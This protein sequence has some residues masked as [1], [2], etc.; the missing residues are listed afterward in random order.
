M[1]MSAVA[2]NVEGT[3]ASIT[4]LYAPGEPGYSSTAQMIVECALF[5]VQEPGKL[6][7]LAAKGGVLTGAL[8]GANRLAERLV[9]NA[10]WTIQ[11]AQSY[12]GKS[13][14]SKLRKTQ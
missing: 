11:P 6:H 8:L 14:V 5:V 9:Q 12:D 7:P 13:R 2:H 1:D 3:K 10:K 4:R